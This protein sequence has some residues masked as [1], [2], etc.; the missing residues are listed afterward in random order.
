MT[1]E[2]ALTKLAYIL[3]KKDWDT[4]T[5]RQLMQTN[6]RGELSAG[7]PPTL[8]DLDLVEAVARS[9]RLSSAVELHDLGAILFPAMLNAAVVRRDT[10]KLE[11]LKGYGADI[12]LT[13]SDGRTAL[14]IACCEGDVNVVRRLLKMG[15]NVHIKDRFNR[16]PLTDAIDFD[17]HVIIKV[18]RQCGAHLH[19][20]ARLIG[21]QM[22]AA[23]ASGNVKRLESYL[24]A[25]ADL[26]QQDL[27][28]RTALH[29]AALHNKPQAVKFLL[30]HGADPRCLDMT[31]RS[32]YEYAE[33]AGA[34]EATA[35]LPNSETSELV[36]KVNAI[37]IR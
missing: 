2:A 10:V 17:H 14:H 37:A 29:L 11:A 16:T 5:K 24:I 1:P 34:K 36:S 30:T 31:D 28:G 8:Q 22:C 6:L 32:P 19:G 21:E 13:N 15:S 20:N 7:R 35:L 18:L 25:G 27:S 33:V 12:S 23:A 3:S 26:S 9:L 4:E